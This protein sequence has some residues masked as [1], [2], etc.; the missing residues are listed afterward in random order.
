MQVAT[1]E[2]IV[3][4]SANK[5]INPISLQPPPESND[6]NLSTREWIKLFLSQPSPEFADIQAIPAD[7]DDAIL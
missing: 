2:S 5:L 3:N 7:D 1:A 6:V 4:H